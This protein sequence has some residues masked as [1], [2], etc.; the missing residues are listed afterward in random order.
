MRVAVYTFMLIMVSCMGPKNGNNADKNA[1][2][3]PFYSLVNQSDINLYAHEIFDKIKIIQLETNEDCNLGAYWTLKPFKDYFIFNN[4]DQS[5]LVFDSNGQ[6]IFKTEHG[7]GPSEV[8]TLTD[9]SIDALK[10]NIL[11]LDESNNQ[12]KLF[13][14]D[15]SFKGKYDLK[16]RT[17]SIASINDTLLCFHIPFNLRKTYNSSVDYFLL[18][19]TNCNVLDS[20]LVERDLESSPYVSKVN[21]VTYTNGVLVHPLEYDTIFTVTENGFSP[22]YTLNYGN[23]KMPEKYYS[24]TREYQNHSKNYLQLT[25]YL[26]TSDLLFLSYRFRKVNMHA[27]YSFSSNSF[28]KTKLSSN[29][30]ETGIIFGSEKAHLYLWPIAVN[31]SN[32][33]IAVCSALDVVNYL[34]NNSNEVSEYYSILI[35]ELKTISEN[36]NPVIFICELSSNRL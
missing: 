29:Q 23:Y 4:L 2:E 27:I 36:D 30:T 13:N 33:L 18:C 21:F 34:Q 24:T 17:T 7:N 20:I 6:F 31:D 25:D 14:L 35:E 32:Q 19:D 28:V 3:I 16:W 26:I 10:M 12:I 9:F 1:T 11:A 15:G 8:V 5:I 22:S